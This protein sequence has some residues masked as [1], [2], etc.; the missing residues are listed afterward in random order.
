LVETPILRRRRRRKKKKKK[1]KKKNDVV[2]ASCITPGLCGARVAGTHSQ[3]AAGTSAGAFIPPPSILTELLVH[4]HETNTTRGTRERPPYQLDDPV[5]VCERESEIHGPARPPARS[6]EKPRRRTAAMMALL[7]P[8]CPPPGLCLVRC[9]S[10][11][12]N[13]INFNMVG[14]ISSHAVGM[15]TRPTNPP[16]WWYGNTQ[17]E[18]AA[19]KH[20]MILL[21]GSAVGHVTLFI[22]KEEGNNH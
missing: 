8:T 11:S 14:F 2:R 10:F 12:I 17:K 22:G 16:S 18:A 4:T 15:F 3:L 9:L 13:K 6:K 7:L 1:K 19:A 5:C 21:P 20:H